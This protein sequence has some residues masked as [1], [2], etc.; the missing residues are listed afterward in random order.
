VTGD[1]VFY[2]FA[3]VSVVSAFCVVFCRNIVHAAFSL[4]FT[5]MGIA[6]LFGMLAADFLTV[7][8]ILVYVGGVLVLIVFTVMMTRV[9]GAPGQSPRANVYV[10]AG[11]FALAV[12]AAIYRLI[13]VSDWGG[14]TTVASQPVTAELGVQVMTNY[15]FAFEYV[16]LALLVAMI[17]AAIVIRE[18]KERPLAAAPVAPD[19]PDAPDGPESAP[20]SGDQTQEVSP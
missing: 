1:L 6:G 3:A 2:L 8:Q 9:P 14:A 5:L 7:A 12:F 4:L 19:A 15:I 13:T 10:P 18:R 16:S 20:G 11:I 17:G